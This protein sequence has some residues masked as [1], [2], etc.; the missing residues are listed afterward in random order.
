MFCGVG[1]RLAIIEVEKKP[2][3]I[4]GFVTLEEGEFF[5]REVIRGV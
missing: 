4:F 1:K 3:D 2:C 5:Q